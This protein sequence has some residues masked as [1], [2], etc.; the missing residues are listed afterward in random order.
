MV[1]RVRANRR[2]ARLEYHVRKSAA[3]ERV[4]QGNR[5]LLSESE[6]R[7]RIFRIPAR[8]LA[9]SASPFGRRERF[10]DSPRATA[11][12]ELYGLRLAEAAVFILRPLYSLFLSD[13]P[14][15]ETSF[16]TGQKRL[17]RPHTAMPIRERQERQRFALPQEAPTAKA[18]Y[19]FSY[20]LAPRL[21][22]EMIFLQSFGFHLAAFL[23]L[24]SPAFSAH[25]PAFKRAAGRRFQPSRPSR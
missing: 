18:A 24:L 3:S 21:V 8:C 25:S 19:V 20:P 9:R 16:R 13:A 4:N 12:S 14:L 10:K 11:R 22:L 6:Y 2:R 23:G 7:P 15:A 5:I 17:L 1:I